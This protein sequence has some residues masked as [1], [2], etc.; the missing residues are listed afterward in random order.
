M[1]ARLVNGDLLSHYSFS[2]HEI[3]NRQF[4]VQIQSSSAMILP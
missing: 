4:S 2:W 1:S 3:C